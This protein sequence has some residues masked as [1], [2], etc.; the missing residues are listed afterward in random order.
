MN[1]NP[2]RQKAL[3]SGASD[4]VVTDVT[5]VFISDYAFPAIQANA[6]YEKSLSAVYCV[7]SP[8]DC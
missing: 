2:I 6:L 7:S 1:S 3:D 5:E 8:A 4:S